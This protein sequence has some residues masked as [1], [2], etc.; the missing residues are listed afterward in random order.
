MRADVRHKKDHRRA[1]LIGADLRGA[2]PRIGGVIGA[3]FRGAD[4]T[5]SNILNQSHMDAAKGDAGTTLPPSL[6]RPMHWS[7]SANVGDGDR[8][9][10]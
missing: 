6:T 10:R 4:I 8:Q 9:G 1:D 5:E 3:D 2:G 7:S